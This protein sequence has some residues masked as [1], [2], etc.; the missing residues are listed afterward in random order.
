MRISSFFAIL[1][2]TLLF[3]C[4]NDDYPYSQIPSVVRNSLWTDFPGATEVKFSRSGENFKVAFEVNGIDHEAIIATN[5][6]VLSEKKE[7]SWKTLPV[8]VRESLEKEY[9]E[10][11]IDDPVIIEVGEQIYYQVQVKRFLSKEKL[12][13]DSLGKQDSTLNY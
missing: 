1:A 6:N 9:G 10:E 11:K 12:V 8:E 2:G 3:S 4:D 13:L 5:G 7:V